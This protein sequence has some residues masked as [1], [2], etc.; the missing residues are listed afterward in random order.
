LHNPH[1]LVLDP[2]LASDLIEALYPCA[3]VY[4]REIKHCG[5]LTQQVN[6][7]DY[8]TAVFLRHRRNDTATE[9]WTFKERYTPPVRPST[10]YLGA[11]EALLS[12]Y[13][14]TY[15]PEI[16]PFSEAVYEQC[17][18]EDMA[19][20]LEK[21]PKSL[22]SIAYRNCPS[23][24]PHKAETFLKAQDITKLGTAFRKAKKG[25]MITGFCTAINARFGGLSRYLYRAT[26]SSL[27]PEILLLNGV[28]LQQQ[29]DW[30]L[31][32]YDFNSPNYED[33]YTGF[34]GTQNEDFL[35]A[36]VGYM[37]LLN[38]PEP[39]ILDYTR[40][41]TH[42]LCML[43]PLGIIIASG[44]KPT[45]FF[46]TF[47]SMCYQ[48]LKH[49]LTP[50]RRPGVRVVARSFSGDDTLHNELVR[51]RPEFAKLPHHFRLVSTGGHTSTPHFC[52]T[53]NT[54][55]GSFADPELLLTRILYKLRAGKLPQCA[56]GYSEHCYRLQ[57]NYEQLTDHLSTRALAC[58]SLS[59]RIL[60]AQLRRS[61][62][63]FFGFFL[64]KLL[65]HYYDLTH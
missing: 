18:E 6:V 13:L 35:A 55:A 40:W 10:T 39:L 46:N 59:L 63:P 14:F 11:G 51:V 12:A 37:R 4:G 36:Q 7:E 43:G 57:R 23:L 31:E 1:A 25:Q 65:S 5:I 22:A 15:S 62:I 61:G 24:D 49:D 26:R 34:D 58:H 17:C 8:A 29:E 41:V 38:L 30:F 47:D 32:H 60:R 33:D 42:L 53:L 3:P 64:T 45:W 56:L 19:A 16:P 48:A 28:T 54:P 27:P 50:H 52:G 2:T 21:G 9:S 20:L 44:F